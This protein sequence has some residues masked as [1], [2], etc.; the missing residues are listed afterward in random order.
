MNHK[1]F[2]NKYYNAE[3]TYLLLTNPGLPDEP[4]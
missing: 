3:A 4:L 1:Q 2:P